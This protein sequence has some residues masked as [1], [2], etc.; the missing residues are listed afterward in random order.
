MKKT[1]LWIVLA[2]S[3]L[4]FNANAQTTIFSEDF[5]TGVLPA[6]WTL[7]DADNDGN[8]WEPETPG[9]GNDYNGYACMS[10]GSQS[11]NWL[12][13]PA[14][15]LGSSSSLTFYR[16][17][18]FFTQGH[19]GVYISTTSPTDVSSFTQLFQ[20]TPVSSSYAWT[21]QTLSLGDY[22]NST[23]Y[24]AFRH[25]NT[26]STGPIMIDDIEVTSTMSSPI[27]MA[28]PASL[29]FLNV[30]ANTYS[31]PQLV[32]V[33]TVNVTGGVTAT[34]N[35]P[36]EL[37]TDSVTFNYGVSLTD[38]DHNLYVRYSPTLSGEDSAVVSLTGSGAVAEVL[39]YGSAISC[40][41]PAGLSVLSLTSTSALLNWT[42]N[43]DNYNIYYKVASATEWDSIENVPADTAGYVLANLT[44]STT[45]NWYVA[46]V[47]DD[48]TLISSTATGTFTTSCGAF[49][50]PFVQGFDASSLPQ[51]W[52]QYT[53]LASNVFAGGV[54][55]STT[56][57]WNFY[58]TQV[59]GAH[60]ARLNIYGTSVNRWLVTPAIDLSALTTPTLTFD[61]AL[62]AWNSAAA[63][64]NPNGQPDDKF[65]VIVSTDDG[66]TWS[67]ANATVWSNDSIGDYIYNQIPAAG[68]EITI[69]LA[70]YANQTVRIAFYGESTVE[71]GD[72]DLH[73]DNV[74]VNNAVS[75]AKLSDLTVTAVTG[76]SVTL[77]WVENGTATSWNVEYG[78]AGYQQGS[79]AATVVTASTA[80]FTISNLPVA[81]YDFY[82]QAD[83]GDEQ[84]LWVGPV[85]ATPGSF[86]MGL[87]GTDTLTTCSTIVYDNGGAGG[88][89]TA[90]CD[91][92][93]VLMPESAG[94]VITVTGSYLTEA[95]CDSLRVFDGA[96][97]TGT[98]LGLYKG[99]GTIPLL[100]SS[101]GP[102][103]LHFKSDYGLQYEGFE[104]TVSCA[105]CAAPGNLTVSNIGPDSAT[106]TWTGISGLY[107]V[108]YKADQD[109]AWVS[110]TTGDTTLVLS[111]LTESTPYT[112]RVY[113][114]C[115][116][117][118]S[119][120]VTATFTTTMMTA[121]IPYSTDFS[122][123]SGW[124]LNNGSCGNY[125][126]IASVSDTANAM[127]VTNNGTTP[128]YA[129][130][131]TFSAVSAEKLF[132]VG[133]AAEI[134]ISFDV[135]IG[136][137]TQ[138]DYLKVFFA[139]ADA[140]YPAATTNT[141]YT[142]E[143]YS[144]YAVNFSDY[145]QYSTYTSL[146]YKFNLTNGNTV[147][148][149]VVMPNPNTNP[150]ANSTAKLVFL[151]KNDTSD[152]TQPGTIVR[153]VSVEAVYCAAP[154]TLT[155]SNITTTGADVTWNPAGSE[156]DWMVEYKAE[157]AST[158]TSLPV[159]GTPACSLTGLTSGS[160]YQ[161][162]VQA[163][164]STTEQS[165][166]VSTQFNTFC[167][168]ITNFPFT[169][170]FENGG[171]MPDCWSQEYVSG[172]LSWDFQAGAHSHGIIHDAHGGN[173][174]AYLFE[175]SNE[176]RTTRLV[177][178]VLNLTGVTSPY[179]TYWYAQQAWGT[180]QDIL[181]VQYRV[182]PNDPWLPLTQHSSSVS[183]WTK[184]SLALPNPSATYQIAFTGLIS[185]GHGI[186][187]DDITVDGSGSAPVVTDPTVTTLAATNIS[188][189][190]A[191]LNGAITNPDNV[192]ITARGF[193]LTEVGT[194]DQTTITVAGG[195]NSFSTDL[196]NLTAETAYSFRAFITF[197]GNTVFGEAMTFTTEAESGDTT[198]IADRLAASVT[199]YPNPA[200]EVVNVQCTMYN[201]QCTMNNVQSGGEMY[202]FDV[203]G[204]LLQIVPITS[205]TTQINVSGLAD[206]VYFVRVTTDR[207]VVTKPF[208]KK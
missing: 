128:G 5:E 43:A 50:A 74:V 150:N 21:L 208:V 130:G 26:T 24:I 114:D 41:L 189:T 145:L 140:Q 42:G 181:S 198:G 146:P 153:H 106:L 136:G 58:N 93:L 110:Q 98:M 27:I 118:F 2:A 7:I 160:V 82:V 126:T 39:L 80:P 200:K 4:V 149:S 188:Q 171:Q 6:G 57:G 88:N 187:L 34:V 173:Y 52:G 203:Y 47:C 193:E 79:A 205:E 162:R 10:S 147:H 109:T 28:T 195:G 112:V 92:T 148:V 113:S 105:N 155:V 178:P 135:Q 184:D 143:S 51:C 18:G 117:N 127:F 15:H 207:G 100:A 104:L 49:T 142:N 45:Y 174:N 108:E 1:L 137:E 156:D 85:A 30:T 60:H 123:T 164:C 87:Q 169:E 206:G 90:S 124:V 86:N 54:L 172:S 185:Y 77:D 131:G 3:M 81:A 101:T 99:T 33:N 32:T 152:G 196:T 194:G 96:G 161:V 190:A 95:C 38:I 89:Y 141:V 64:S 94:S 48:G 55:T 132:T 69:S 107:M 163:L 20:E 75:C 40:D 56:S 177:S 167:D 62:T 151:W 133:T 115:G 201:V 70:D 29:Q 183:T 37:S 31:A 122:N 76:N 65:M 197:D 154:T 158:W 12:V 204:K 157:N 73:V 84:S 191:T 176:G 61:L 165:L 144:T 91:Y 121:G 116:D 17:T 14:I 59:F 46:A 125:W 9:H 67:A 168:A 25:F 175:E 19:Y 23:V 119:P 202:L 159:S 129:T 44:P 22:D 36:F 66:V 102:L 11:D 78:P 138:F 139:P 53:G 35:A 120:A 8:G 180:D 170:N 63:I 16:A 192:T 13:T 72:N 186:V 199:V 71:N 182:S 179:L 97:T 111:G 68:Q 83:C 166:W 103:T 134:A